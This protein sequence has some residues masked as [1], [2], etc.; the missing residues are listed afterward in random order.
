MSKIVNLRQ[1]RKRAAREEK[2]RQAETAR[3]RSGRSK[4]D[5]ERDAAEDEKARQR[6]DGHYIGSQAPEDE[7]A[8]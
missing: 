2:R 8:R 7:P 3:A 5:K 4:A 6:L 1:H